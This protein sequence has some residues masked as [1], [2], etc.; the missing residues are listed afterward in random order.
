ML[1]IVFQGFFGLSC[2]QAAVKEILNPLRLLKLKTRLQFADIKCILSTCPVLRASEASILLGRLLLVFLCD[3]L[4]GHLV[5][6]DVVKL[7]SGS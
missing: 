6:T 3:A 2:F 4:G 5:F 7:V 1:H